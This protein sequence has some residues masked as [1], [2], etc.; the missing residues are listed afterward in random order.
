MASFDGLGDGFQGPQGTATL[1]NPSDNSLAVGPDH[2]M[3]T[4]NGGMAIFTKKGAKFNTTGKVL[5]GPTPA[6]NVFRGFGDYGS[7]GGGDVVRRAERGIL[8]IRFPESSF[9]STLRRKLGWGGLPER[10]ALPS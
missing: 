4:V 6:G 9:F 1:R 5:Y 3:Q 7:L 8:I 10:D 2:I